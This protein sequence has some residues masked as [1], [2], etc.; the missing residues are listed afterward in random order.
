MTDRKKI[1]AFQP[2]QNQVDIMAAALSAYRVCI[3]NAPGYF[4]EQYQEVV[5]IIEEIRVC[6]LVP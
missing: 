6:A 4:I 3:M 1:I 5:T 2:T